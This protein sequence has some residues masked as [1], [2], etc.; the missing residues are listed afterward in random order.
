MFIHI[1]N[2]YIY[3][4]YIK[5]VNVREDTQFKVQLISFNIQDKTYKNLINNEYS[6]LICNSKGKV[7][8]KVGVGHKT[9]K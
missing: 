8:C 1:Y 6:H 7:K 5:S 2:I 3:I 9:R 4:Y